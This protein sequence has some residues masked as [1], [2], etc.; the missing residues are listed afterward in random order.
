MN[1]VIFILSGIFIQQVVG[2]NN[3]SDNLTI[4]KILAVTETLQTGS[5]SQNNDTATIATLTNYGLIIKT[6]VDVSQ[7]T[8][9][10]SDAELSETVLTLFPN[11][12]NDI[13]TFSINQINS[14]SVFDIKGRRVLEVNSS[15]FSV[16]GLAKGVYILRAITA[17]GAAISKKLIKN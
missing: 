16:K 17:N 14:A 2:T 10:D 3:Q 9:S 15:S 8:L 7:L 1:S 11:P 4:N 12:S 6:N 13:V 5:R